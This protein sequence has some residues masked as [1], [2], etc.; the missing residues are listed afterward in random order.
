VTEG[1]GGRRS[2]RNARLRWLALAL[3]AAVLAALLLVTVTGND[4]DSGPST[5]TAGPS[6]GGTPDPG[7][8]PTEPP[9]PVTEAAAAAVVVREGVPE[10]A[11]TVE[12]SQADFAGPAEWSDGAS[13]RVVEA[14]QQ[15]SGGEGPG[16]LAG[17]PQTV[18]VLELS[19]GTD[20][21][22][23]LNGVVVQAA[24][25]SSRTQAGPLYDQETVDFGGVLE[26]GSAATAVYS[27]AVPEE[28]LGD[29]LLSVDV[30]GYRFPAVFSGA[31]P[32]R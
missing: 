19:N 28:E 31:V 24:Y 14:R 21:P 26:P 4:G 12:A 30:D 7:A 3:G 5:S 20:Q 10:S 6:A 2:L 27:F 17:Q 9:S 29:V 11:R 23:D 15:V 8:T 16:S 32:V 25:G 18:F 1:A 22:L 13:I